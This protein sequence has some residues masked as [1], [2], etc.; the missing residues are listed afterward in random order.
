M[1]SYPVFLVN[2]AEKHCVVVG[3]GCEAQRKVE[4]LVECDAAVTVISPEVT[5][6]LHS[7]VGEGMMTWIKRDYRPGDLRGAFLAIAATDDPQTNARIWEEAETEGILVNAV[8]APSCCN[9]ISGSVVRQGPLTIAIST[10]GCAPAL[11]VRLRQ[12]LQREFGP[13][14][15]T[16]L[17]WMGALRAPLAAHLPDFQARRAR[18]YALVD[19]DVLDLLREGRSDLARQRVAAIIGEEVLATIEGVVPREEKL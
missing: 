12:Q 17:D 2:L 1:K 6:Q 19:S 5:N 7:W 4:S 11:A 14:Y 16:F 18:W 8:D 10:G 9:F 13:E 15:A 3:G